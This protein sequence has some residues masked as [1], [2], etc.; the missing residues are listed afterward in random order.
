MGIVDQLEVI[1]INH[2]YA[3]RRVETIGAMKLGFRDGYD[4]RPIGQ[5]GEQ[6]GG[7][8][9]FKIDHQL[10]SALERLFA[11]IAQQNDGRESAHGNHGRGGEIR[12]YAAQQR[13]DRKRY[14][15]QRENRH[16]DGDRVQHDDGDKNPDHHLSGHQDKS[17]MNR[18]P[19]GDHGADH[20]KKNV[21][22]DEQR[23]GMA[24][25]GR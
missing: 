22:D 15:E 16:R 7:R 2:Q 11:Q 6:I 25:D 19:R 13:I 4:A 20:G 3:D 8:G 5:A 10:E 14:G 21:N 24:A 1:D 18:Q 23:V 12:R 9:T 17:R